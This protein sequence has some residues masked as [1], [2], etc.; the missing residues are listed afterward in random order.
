[1]DE[2]VCVCGMGTKWFRGRPD[3]LGEEVFGRSDGARWW[4]DLVGKGPEDGTAE[5][6]M[7]VCV[8]IAC[9][10]RRVSRRVRVLV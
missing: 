10:Y 5:G 7:V 2:C 4:W 6:R 1:M 8:D 9:E 3:V